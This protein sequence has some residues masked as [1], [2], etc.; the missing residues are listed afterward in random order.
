MEPTRFIIS[1]ME[2]FAFSP[3]AVQEE[4]SPPLPLSYHGLLLLLLPWRYPP[5]SWGK[6]F[7]NPDSLIGW[8]RPD[9]FGLTG[10]HATEVLGGQFRLVDG[11]LIQEQLRMWRRCS[12]LTRQTQVLI[13]RCDY[14]FWRSGWHTSCHFEFKVLSQLF[15][16]FLLLVSALI[17]LRHIVRLSSNIHRLFKW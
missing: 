16:A 15:S 1:W 11:Q 13:D 8:Q 3:A 9:R 14:E 10:Q 2:Q 12:G 4:T 5:V 17:V 6:R 7:N